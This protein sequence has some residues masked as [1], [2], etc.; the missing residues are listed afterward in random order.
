MTRRSFRKNRP[1]L[2]V[3]DVGIEGEVVK[4]LPSGKLGIIAP[5]NGAPRIFF[6]IADVPRDRLK[7]V[8]KGR[9]VFFDVVERGVIKRKSFKKPRLVAV[10]RSSRT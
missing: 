4:I 5:K 8:G 9:T 6:S 3:G 10:I 2:S 7:C 1:K